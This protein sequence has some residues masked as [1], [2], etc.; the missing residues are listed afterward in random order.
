M[1][2]ITIK[3]AA[4]RWGIAERTVNKFCL[5]GRISGA[6]KFGAAWAI[7]EDA[8]KPDGSRRG[9][10]RPAT[11][12]TIAC[13]G[14]MAMADADAPNAEP[15]RRIAMPLL[16]TAFKPGE[17][18]TAI[19]QMED[20]DTRNIA[21][22]EYFY[23]SGRSEKVAELV[24]PYL[25]H[26]DIALRISAR[27]L[28]TY[29]NLVVGKVAKTRESLDLITQMVERLNEDTP[30]RERAYAISASTGMSVL[31]HLPVPKILDSLQTYIHMMPSGLRLFV[32]Y[33]QA[34]HAYL[35]KYYGTAIGIAETALALESEV[36]PIPTIY[37]HL[38]ACVGY[39]HMKHPEHAKA[40]FLK[41]W[42]IAQPD[43]L[44]HPLAELH[45]L[46]GGTLEATL[47]R[48]FPHDFKRI[49]ALT[50]RFSS[51]WRKV[52][53]SITG[54]TVPEDLTT[55]EYAAAMLAAQGWTNQEIADHM[56]V[57][58][59]TVKSFISTT[60]Q[61]LNISQRTDLKNHLWM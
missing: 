15:T 39:L 13:E 28:S 53:N 18:L 61:K 6:R 21:L 10:K 24:E 5:N 38:I 26:E 25:M 12:R 50:Y 27:W 34:H 8:E 56:G 16:S 52:H 29:A 20:S 7:P 14:S 48:M 2:Y 30:I 40:H 59:N 60:F 3:E 49:I 55:S 36:Y 4:L 35:C 54:H 45:G 46:V 37:L 19:E 42:E 22:A 58:E 44:I 1:R 11:D 31:L 23:F 51:G 9:Q 41:A 33:I 17:C 57:T 43:D 32:L 47:K